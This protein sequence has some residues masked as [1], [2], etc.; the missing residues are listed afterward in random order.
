MFVSSWTNS[1]IRRQPPARLGHIIIADTCIL[2]F[3]PLYIH[4]DYLVV[5]TVINAGRWLPVDVD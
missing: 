2:L 4:F 5:C 3:S 1:C